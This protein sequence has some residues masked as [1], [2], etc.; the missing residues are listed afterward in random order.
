MAPSVS[1]FAAQPDPDLKHVRWR[2]LAKSLIAPALVLAFFIIAP[3][4]YDSRVR[5]RVLEDIE[6][7]APPS[8]KTRLKEI[9]SR[10]SY[11]EVC[12]S[13]SPESADL[14]A[15][16]Q[17]GGV[18]RTFHFLHW[19]FLASVALLAILLSALGLI[20]LLN[21]RAGASPQILAR[22]YRLAWHIGIAAA[23]IQLLLLIPLLTYAAFM[24][25]VLAAD[26]WYPKLLIVIIIC[27]LIALVSSITVLVKKLPLEFQ[28]TMA[29]EVSA[30]DAPELWQAVRQAAERLQTTAPD[31]ILIGMK[32]NFYVTELAV[33]HDNGVASGKTLY[34]SHPLLRQ[35]SEEEIL[36]IVGHELGHFIGEDTRLTREFYPMRMKVHGTMVA[37]ARSGFV[38]W[39]TLHFLNFFTWSFGE[40]EQSMSRQRELLADAKAAALTSPT[41]AARALVKFQVVAEALNLGFVDA[42]RTADQNPLELPLRPIIVNK[43]VPNAEFWSGLFEKRIP[44]PMDSHPALHVRLESLGQQITAS[45]A[46]AVAIEDTLPAYARWFSGRDTVFTDLTRQAEAAVGKMR[47]AAQVAE[48]DYATDAG[49]Q[50]LDSH[51]PERKWPVKPSSVTGVIVILLAFLVFSIIGGVMIDLLVARLIAGAIATCLALITFLFWKRHRG[52]EFTVNADRMTYSGWNRPVSFREIDRI[53]GQKTY[54]S[55]TVTFRLKEKQPPLWKMTLFPFARRTLNL[56]I[57]YFDGKPDEIFETIVRYCT[58][59]LK[60]PVSPAA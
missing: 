53:G 59:Q 55:V 38:S 33:R 27:G 5:A 8:N 35:L 40:T 28:E 56:T 2:I 7:N 52:A 54:G 26:A 11:R 57:S 42:L 9:F 6:A 22:N 14:R 60:P 20:F 23:L 45:D 49:R 25:T 46:Q 48:A 39:S 47:S 31:R 1:H 18:C 58:R 16:L 4:W 3:H 41:I 19:A 51:F 36:S 37:L 15:S 29:R 24:L 30:D 12:F 21:T 44:H 43:L 32:L 17:K 50:L 10:I 13:N 34:L